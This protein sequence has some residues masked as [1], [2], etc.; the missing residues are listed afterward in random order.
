MP[1]PGEPVVVHVELE[2]SAY[3]KTLVLLTV[4]RLRFVLPLLAF[5]TCAAIGARNVSSAAFLVAGTAGLVLFSW[6]YIEWQVHSP[7]AREVYRPVTYA[8][9]ESGIE[10]ELDDSGGT[11]DWTV[12]RRWRITGAHYVLQAAGG[13]YLLIPVSSVDYRDRARFERLLDERVRR[14]RGAGS[15]RR[16]DDS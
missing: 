5:F 11:I 6:G 8:F 4:T 1:E 14:G 13:R 7:A 2:P 12:I 9:R 15:P 10:Y 16:A 3:R